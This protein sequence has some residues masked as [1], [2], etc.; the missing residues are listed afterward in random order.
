VLDKEKFTEIKKSSIK[1]FTFIQETIYFEKDGTF[2]DPQNLVKINELSEN[3][4]LDLTGRDGK[5][6][7]FINC[8]FF[9][10]IFQSLPTIMFY[11]SR[12][13]NRGTKLYIQELPKTET[14]DWKG[15]KD[16][17]IKYLTDIEVE[18]E[19][20][21]KK[22][23]NSIKINNCWI[24]HNDFS[25]L[26]IRILN[27]KT[28]KYLVSSNIKP[29]RKIFVARDKSLTQRV[30][31][32]SRIQKFF[33]DAGFEIVYPEQF[34]SFIDQINY[35]SECKVL[36]GISGSALSNSVFMK[37]GGTV[38]E[39]L[40][41]FEPNGADC[42]VEIHHYYKIMANV[43]RHLYL[44][45]SNLSGESEDFVNNKNALDVIKML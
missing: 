29:F 45:I 21:N 1:D 23:L 41:I 32:D 26:G 14:K 31:D 38:I 16:F 10:F 4:I 6:M 3:G 13:I 5:A 9:T 42:P 20:L 44:S 7:V 25:P 28:K 22:T 8:S 33:V 34:N 39:L 36:S 15:A 11:Y 24:L 30:D 27:S 43:M 18:F 40:S 35:F 17:L 2:V 19:F 12:I 37:P